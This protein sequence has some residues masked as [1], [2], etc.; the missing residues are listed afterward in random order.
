MNR[1]VQKQTAENKKDQAQRDNWNIQKH[2]FIFIIDGQ[3]QR[4]LYF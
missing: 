2:K 4:V 3:I 1:T